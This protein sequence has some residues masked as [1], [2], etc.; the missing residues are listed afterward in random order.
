[1]DDT[2]GVEKAAV[3]VAEGE[4]NLPEIDPDELFEEALS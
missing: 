3:N 4:E 1:M 2:K